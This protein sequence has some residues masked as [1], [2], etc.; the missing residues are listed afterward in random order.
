MLAMPFERRSSAG[1]DLM[2][3]SSMGHP[4][5]QTNL[6][7]LRQRAG[8]TPGQLAE[9]LGVTCHA[10]QAWERGQR[11][12]RKGWDFK[13]AEALGC[14]VGDLRQAESVARTRRWRRAWV[15]LTDAP[16]SPSARP[17]DAEQ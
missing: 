6:R 8:L 1:R 4:R 14:S 16:K 17:R 7:Q 5:W 13:L 2:E 11:A 10:I 12:V 15:S 3:R 9:R